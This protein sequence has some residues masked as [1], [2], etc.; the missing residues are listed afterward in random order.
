MVVETLTIRKR[1]M[2]R[3]DIAEIQT[4]VEENWGQGRTRISR[5]LCRK[6]GWVQ[7]SGRLK[8]MACREILLTLHRKGLIPLPPR[9]TSANND[10]RNRRIL[11]VEID[12]T[13]M[14][15][16]LRDFA[17][18]GLHLVRNSALEPLYA[19]LLDRY[20]YLGYRQIVGSHLKYMA[21]L[22]ERPVAC[23]GWGSAA[24]R[25]G[26]REEFIG[27]DP[28]TKVKNLSMVAN[29]TR[30]L[31]LPW[32]SIKCLASKLLSLN[33]KRI[34]QDWLRIY[35]L[36]IHLLETFVERDRFRGTCYQA[37]NWI[38][39]GETKG[40]AKRGHDH[41]FHGSI[42]DV[43]LYPLTKNFRKELCG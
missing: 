28:V 27:W 40:M 37:A 8:D 36:P 4:V 31:I 6:W 14:A 35:H 17:S 32:V 29:N 20:H 33:A 34:S 9:V 18:L 25:V 3:A 21:F 30:F 7:P 2:T 11:P 42:K 22:G 43:Y 24:W 23:L 15:G 10:K 13:P 38:H 26:C 39:V 16:K 19:S 1:T 41:R 5:I 12:Q